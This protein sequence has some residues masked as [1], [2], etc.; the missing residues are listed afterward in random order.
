MGH[1]RR[2]QTTTKRGQEEMR[3]SSNKKSTG[4]PNPNF[5]TLTN[6]RALGKVGKSAKNFRGIRGIFNE[7]E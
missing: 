2:A 3:L 5:L 4:A 7:G 6:A 1:L